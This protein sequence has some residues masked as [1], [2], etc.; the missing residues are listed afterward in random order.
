MES[1]H[2]HAAET[3]LADAADRKPDDSDLDLDMSIWIYAKVSD[4]V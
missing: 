2:G 3:M 4:D 1:V